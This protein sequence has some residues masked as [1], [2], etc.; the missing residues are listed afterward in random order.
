M[1][2]HD[3]V[4]LWEAHCRYE[5]ETHDVDATMA[6]M[7]DA[8]YVNNVPTMTGGVGHDQVK[9]FYKY[10]FIDANAADTQITP[11]SRTVGVDQ[12]VDE[13]LFSFTHSGRARLD[14]ARRRA[15]R[16]E[17]RNPLG[18]DRSLPGRRRS[19]TSTSTGTRPRSWC[20]SAS[21]IPRALPVAGV[22]TARKVA[23]KTRPTNG[24]MRRWSTSEG[25]PI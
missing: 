16:A 24:L 3:L 25:K 22:E 23:D 12:I 19:R 4:A 10:H 21:S 17:G 20:R 18:G 13:L 7:I 5:F 14:A 6:T 2:D 8:P 9:R 15:D 11:I 1:P